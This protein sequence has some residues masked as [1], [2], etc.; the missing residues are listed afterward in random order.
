MDIIPHLKER[1]NI[2]I[3]CCMVIGLFILMITVYSME[4]HYQKNKARYWRMKYWQECRFIRS[5][6]YISRSAEEAIYKDKNDNTVLDFS[7]IDYIWYHGHKIDIRTNHPDGHCDLTEFLNYIGQEQKE[8][9]MQEIL[10][11]LK[12]KLFK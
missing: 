6:S 10:E 1:L 4:C 5:Y 3:A 12:R 9:F 11:R 2:Y 8:G 7:K